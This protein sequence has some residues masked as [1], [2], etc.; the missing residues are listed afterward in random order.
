MLIQMKDSQCVYP[1]PNSRQKL[2]QSS[3]LA[4]SLTMF[5][6]SFVHITVLAK[7]IKGD[8]INSWR[9][10]PSNHMS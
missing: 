1:I 4:I 8:Y 9:G 3:I 5:V 6:F 10:S 7:H 2:L